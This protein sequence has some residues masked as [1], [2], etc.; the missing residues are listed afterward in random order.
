MKLR[1][2]Q[3]AQHVCRSSQLASHGIPGS[4]EPSTRQLV[5]QRLKLVNVLALG[6][7]APS[8]PKKVN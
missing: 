2:F 6:S 5:I 1:K 7:A 3:Q 4:E 8:M